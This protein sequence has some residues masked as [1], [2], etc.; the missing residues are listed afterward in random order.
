MGKLIAIF[1]IFTHK[2]K[3]K[4]KIKLFRRL[5]FLKKIPQIFSIESIIEDFRDVK[6]VK[7][8][9]NRYLQ[10]KYQETFILYFFIR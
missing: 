10:C 3:K 2:K 5:F 7:F 6:R 1:N 9:F 8:H 4:K